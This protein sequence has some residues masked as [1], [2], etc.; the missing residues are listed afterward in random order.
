[1]APRQIS[2]VFSGIFARRRDRLGMLQMVANSR[3][4]T[5]QRREEFPMASELDEIRRRQDSFE[6]RLATLEVKVEAEARMRA[7]MDHDISDI[8]IE[9]RAQRGLLQAVAITL[10]EHS[11]QLTSINE[12]LTVVKDR[13]GNL[14]QGQGNIQVG[15][16]T[17][18][19]ILDRQIDDEAHG[20][21][22]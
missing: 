21:G 19:A 8:K 17:I 12:E 7:A 5:Q 20:T 15:V 3:L 9:Q 13:L 10:S 1:M 16:Q 18:I 4:Q 14:E 2:W 11:A 22:S 6:V